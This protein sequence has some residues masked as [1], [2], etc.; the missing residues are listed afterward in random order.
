[1]ARFHYCVMGEGPGEARLSSRVCC[2]PVGRG[3]PAS[4]ARP[5]AWKQRSGPGTGRSAGHTALQ[6]KEGS[7]RLIAVADFVIKPSRQ[8]E[9][10]S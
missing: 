7:A 6:R 9:L 10:Q 8:N 3:Q 1:M 4:P 2:R 5:E